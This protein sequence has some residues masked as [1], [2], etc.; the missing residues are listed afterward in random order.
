MVHL[1]ANHTLFRITDERKLIVAEKLKGYAG[2]RVGA[3][4]SDFRSK[5]LHVFTY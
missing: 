2:E 5:N 1:D 3:I 4:G